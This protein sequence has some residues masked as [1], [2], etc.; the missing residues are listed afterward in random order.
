MEEAH[1][2]SAA[3][4]LRRFSVTAEGGLSLEQVT[5]ARERYGPNGERGFLPCSG[6]RLS[7]PD[8]AGSRAQ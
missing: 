2:L 6:D 1:L 5:D 7:P 3:D 4:V 8:S